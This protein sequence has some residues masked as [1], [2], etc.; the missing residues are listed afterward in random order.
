MIKAAIFDMDGLLIDSEPFWV[1]AEKA[2]FKKVGLEISNE[3]L[4]SHMGTKIDEVVAYRFGQHPWKGASQTDIIASIV[5]GVL[6][7]IR[8]GGKAKK[9]VHE[10]LDL[11]S[12]LG[13]PMSVASSSTFEIIET[14]LNKLNIRKYFQF[15][16]SAEKEKYGKPHPAVY[17]ST[18]ELLQIPTFQCLAFEDSPAGVLAAK[19]AR[20]HCVAVP[21][22]QNREHSYIKIA[23]LVLDSLEQFNASKLQT[24]SS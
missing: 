14:T 11:F 24:F 9:G 2:A 10:I 21:A 4:E 16:H 12:S 6:Q 13:I 7:Q 17:V 3:D 23:D 15:I 5:D 20:M 8:D 1:K 18:A 19:S 22:K